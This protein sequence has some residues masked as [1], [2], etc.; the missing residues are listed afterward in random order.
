MYSPQ[1]HPGLLKLLFSQEVKETVQQELR[2]EADASI[3]SK[4]PRRSVALVLEKAPP[5]AVPFTLR[6]I[7]ALSLHLGFVATV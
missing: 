2:A 7:G 1:S 5:I 4:H 3:G 6:S